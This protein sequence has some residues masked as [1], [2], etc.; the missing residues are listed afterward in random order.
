MINLPNLPFISEE[1]LDPSELVVLYVKDNNV[2]GLGT[3]GGTGYIQNDGAGTITVQVED[4]NG[5][6]SEASTVNA[7]EQLIFEKDDEVDIAIIYIQADAIGASYRAR[8]A[9]IR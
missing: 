9:R 7:N 6:A 5:K 1:T 4:E 8:F 2:F 3:S